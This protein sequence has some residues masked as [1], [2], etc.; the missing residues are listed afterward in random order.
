MASFT[1]EME[2]FK[3]AVNDFEKKGDNWELTENFQTS[4]S[5]ELFIRKIPSDGGQAEI[6]KFSDKE[7]S[8][9]IIASFGFNGGGKKHRKSMK[10][11]KQLRK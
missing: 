9:R 7:F 5:P 3:V 1:F 4:F 8:K 6:I 11:I 10:R 2:P